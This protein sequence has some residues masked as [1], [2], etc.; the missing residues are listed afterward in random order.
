LAPMILPENSVPVQCT[1]T[2]NTID[3][4][5]RLSIIQ[6]GTRLHQTPTTGFLQ[7]LPPWQSQLLTC[8]RTQPMHYSYHA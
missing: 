3:I 5:V 4:Q 2:W 6:S 8:I 7:N 1:K